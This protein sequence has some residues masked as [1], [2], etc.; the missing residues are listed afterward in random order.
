M[1]FSNSVVCKMT[2]ITSYCNPDVCVDIDY[3]NKIVKIYSWGLEVV[4]QGFE[5]VDVLKR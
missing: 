1:N 2:H 4:V 5:K 3:E